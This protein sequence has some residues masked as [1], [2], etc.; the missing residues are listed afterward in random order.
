M[1]GSPLA[2]LEAW[3]STL[4]EQWEMSMRFDEDGDTSEGR[5]NL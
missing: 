5:R 1:T 4:A 2:T 3:S